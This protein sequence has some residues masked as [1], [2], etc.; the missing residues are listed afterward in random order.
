MRFTDGE[1]RNAWLHEC[2]GADAENGQPPL[3]DSGTW[4]SRLVDLKP[5]HFSNGLEVAVIVVQLCSRLKTGSR[6]QAVGGLANG[7]SSAATG[8]IDVCGM[9]EASQAPHPQ[10]RVGSKEISR[11]AKLVLVEDAL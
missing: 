11:L 8:A 3:D 9:L 10:D 7:K 2:C 1:W 4:I 5:S 6:N